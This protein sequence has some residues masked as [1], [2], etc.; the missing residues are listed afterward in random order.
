MKSKYKNLILPIELL[1]EENKFLNNC[2]KNNFFLKT[3]Q[4]FMEK[5]YK[6]IMQKKRKIQN[7]K[8]NIKYSNLITKK[9]N[10]NRKNS[11]KTFSEIIDIL[12]NSSN[13]SN[14]STNHININS[15]NKNNKPKQT[16]SK[17]N[18]NNNH[19]LS[20]KINKKKKI[21]L[22]LGTTSACNIKNKFN[23]N[24]YLN[25]YRNL[26]ERN[27]S[28]NKSHIKTPSS[29]YNHTFI[30]NPHNE[31]FQDLNN[32]HFQKISNRIYKSKNIPTLTQIQLISYIKKNNKNN[33]NNN[34][35]TLTNSSNNNN[36]I[37][38]KSKSKS[39]SKNNKKKQN[40]NFIDNFKNISNNLNYNFLKFPIKKIN[41]IK[42]IKNNRNFSYNKN[43]NIPLK[44]KN[45]HKQRKNIIIN[46][47]NNSVDNIKKIYDD[48]EGN[49]LF[50]IGELIINRYEIL[51]FLG[52]GSFGNCVK[53]YDHFNKESVCIKIIKNQFNFAEQAQI[54]IKILKYLNKKDYKN[55]S[56]IIKLKNNFIYKKHFCLVFELLNNNLYTELQNTN[57]IGFD[58][59]TIKK[60]A[61][62]I[63][64]AL[65]YLKQ[66]KI[67]HCD[68][69]PEN[70]LLI[71]KGKTGIKLIDFGSS[72]FSS[73]TKYSYI[74]SRFYRAPEI[75]LG[76]NYSC[77]IDMWSLGCV[78]CELFTGFP[79]FP[80]EN[81][82]DLIYYFMEYLGMPSKNLIEF[83]PKKNLFFDENGNCLNKKNSFGKIRKPNKK[84]IEN[85]LKNSDEDFVD[86][87]K[88][89]L[90]WE[91][92]KR[93]TPLMALKH[94]W[95]I[96]NMPMEILKIHLKKINEIIKEKDNNFIKNFNFNNYEN[97][98]IDN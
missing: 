5:T 62:Q 91:V 85:L 14:I 1:T 6:E 39:K 72:C 94:K 49:Y 67:I 56:H 55:Y 60:F 41:S 24:N 31:Y 74:Q 76:F 47:L 12:N 61:T 78:L 59:Q 4:N 73:E 71:S 32:K 50:N 15:N 46:S 37:K 66:H 3:Q 45:N 80:G 22:C 30:N 90:V 96:K 84:S 51:S 29:Y 35:L 17:N 70:I 42:N 93:L 33:K 98:K 64:F 86:F 68:I 20:P 34:N 19:S 79:I 26:N 40:K 87:V 57:F 54:E 43:N 10:Y 75:L 97:C 38:I 88:K 8:T 9:Y 82:Y 69:K 25:T 95:I 7:I 18:K 36:N 52:S 89:C 44:K 11:K 83:S 23:N 81:E 16:N 28:N 77:A 92:E 58:L 27:T 48:E 21:N 13:I 2:N 63:L 65:L 53:C